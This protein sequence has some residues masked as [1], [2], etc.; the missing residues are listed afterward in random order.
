MKISLWLSLL[1]LGI[2]LGV[3]A[4]RLIVGTSAHAQELTTIT[5]GSE[6]VFIGMPKNTAIA[7]FAGKY[8]LDNA[9]EKRVLILP[10]EATGGKTLRSV[11]VLSFEDGKLVAARRDWADLSPEIDGIEPLWNALYGA[12]SQQIGS[13]RLNVGLER[14]SLRKPGSQEDWITVH[15]KTR[16]IEIGRLHVD[17]KNVIS[18]SSTTNFYVQ[19]T[20]F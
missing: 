9:D 20:A 1:T 15:F 11:G 16:D 3:A 2:L 13:E 4:D 19:E 6:S 5:I 7:K 17:D 12:L 14:S 18:P 10:T 8:H